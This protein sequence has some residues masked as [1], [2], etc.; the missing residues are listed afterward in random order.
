MMEM[1]LVVGTRTAV[2]GGDREPSFRGTRC[3]RWGCGGGHPEKNERV[4]G[5]VG[6]GA[7]T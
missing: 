5:S 3:A 1:G 7:R 2:G 4:H 6:D